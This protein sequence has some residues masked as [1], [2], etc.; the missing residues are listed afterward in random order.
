MPKTLTQLRKTQP[1][2]HHTKYRQT[3]IERV[4]LMQHKKLQN[5]TTMN[6]FDVV[7]KQQFMQKSRNI[8]T[9]QNDLHFNY[10]W[11]KNLNINCQEG[12][13]HHSLIIYVRVTLITSQPQIEGW[14]DFHCRPFCQQDPIINIIEIRFKIL[15]IR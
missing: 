13:L 1:F 8:P 11:M 14:W 15:T 12:S 2:Q 5:F 4:P 6:S 9:I 7:V 3:S 10:Q